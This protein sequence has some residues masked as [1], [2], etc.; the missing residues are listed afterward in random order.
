[1]KILINSNKKENTI[2]FIQIPLN[3]RIFIAEAHCDVA[4]VVKYYGNETYPLTHFPYNFIL[5]NINQPTGALGFFWCIYV[6]MSYVPEG[7]ISAWMV[8][9]TNYV[10]TLQLFLRATLCDA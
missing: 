9:N 3:Y 4:T 8:C 5:E 6:W 2:I 1:M 7:E 10:C